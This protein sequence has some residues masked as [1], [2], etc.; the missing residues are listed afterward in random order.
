MCS[1]VAL[2]STLCVLNS[3]IMQLTT[4]VSE[5]PSICHGP[6]TDAHIVVQAVSYSRLLC[7]LFGS[8]S[9]RFRNPTVPAALREL[10]CAVVRLTVL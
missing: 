5:W 1:C 7:N 2:H 4:A 6:H 9:P 3:L 10:Q 8:N